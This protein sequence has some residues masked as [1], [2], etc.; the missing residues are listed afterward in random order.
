MCIRDRKLSVII[1]D[2]LNVDQLIKFKENE[3][4]LSSFQIA[5]KLIRNYP[6]QSIAAHVIGYTQPITESE[7]K[8]LSKKGYKL[9]DLIGRTGIEYVYEDFIRGEWGGEM[10]EVNSLGKFQRSLGIR[11]PVK[12]NDIEL[13]IDLNLQLVA[14]E[15]LKDKKAGA[16]IVMDPRDGAIRAM[17]SR[18]N[19]DL[20][21]F[22]KDFKP[23][24][25]YNNIFNSPEKPLFNR[26]L[27]AYDPGSVLSL[28]HI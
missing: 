5:T 6:Y 27:N 20:N 8:F 26:A 12:G 10:V 16:I 15:V 22:S 13:T 18:P 11:P 14:E 17:V 3:D 19:F 21:F 25:E 2:D 24:K 28:I 1:R 23:E 9:N 7:Y 4:N